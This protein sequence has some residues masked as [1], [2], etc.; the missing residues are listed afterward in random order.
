MV[1][2]CKHT[3]TDSIYVPYFTF[4][5]PS[6]PKNFENLFLIKRSL[7]K[8]GYDVKNM[9]RNIGLFP[10]LII[11]CDGK[12][13]K[14]LLTADPNEKIFARYAETDVEKFLQK[15][16]ELMGTDNPTS[17]KMHN[18]IYQIDN[19]LIDIPEGM[20]CYI[21]NGIV[22]FRP[23]KKEIKKEITYD[24]I[25]KELFFNKNTYYSRNSINGSLDI[26]KVR[27]GNIAFTNFPF[28]CTSEKQVEKLAAYNKLMNVAKYLNGDWNPDWKNWFEDKFYFH[29]DG[30]GCSLEI[31]TTV[32]KNYGGVYFKSKKLIEQSV[33]MLGTE[34][35]KLALSADY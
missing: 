2:N 34:T 7:Y 27:M 26:E 13:G 4:S 12:M 5:N 18:S 16:A 28:N 29:S 3:V 19:T 10:H 17:N 24:D 23:I 1:N 6:N 32:S 15:A 30:D 31:G 33:E 11:N 14:C 8:Y 21:E 22:K 20:E 35:I 25:A 9:G